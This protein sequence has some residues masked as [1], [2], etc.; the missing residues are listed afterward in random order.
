MKVDLAKKGSDQ[1]TSF[2]KDCGIIDC[3][4]KKLLEIGFKNGHFMNTCVDAGLIS[5]GIDISEEFYDAT[6][7]RFPSLDIK[8]YDG[9]VFPVPSDSF[10]CVVSFQVLEHV[11]SIEHILN[12]CVRVLKPG[13]IM[14]HVCPN[15][16]SFYEGHYK[17]IWLPF[18]NK[19]LGRIYLKLLRKYTDRYET[20]NLVNPGML[21]KL[22]KEKQKDLVVLSLGHREFA[23]YFNKKQIAKIKQ[24]VLR[25]VLRVVLAVPFVK[26]LFIWIVSRTNCYYPIKIISKKNERI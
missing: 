25:I 10:D 3:T 6:K 4:N 5:T 19:K 8:L 16:H 14:Y 17:V 12:E 22:M 23:E 2:L 24:P 11:N 20:L 1:L 18:L 7:E 15:Y 9:T 13:G 21:S 26:S